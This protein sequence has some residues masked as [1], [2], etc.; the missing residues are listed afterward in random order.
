MSTA[1]VGRWKKAEECL[2]LRGRWLRLFLRT[3]AWLIAVGLM[4][5]WW[6]LCE[7]LPEIASGGDVRVGYHWDWRLH[8]QFGSGVYS[9]YVDLEL[10]PALISYRAPL[11]GQRGWIEQPLRLAMSLAWMAFPF[12]LAW[13]RLRGAAFRK[14]A[15]GW[16]LALVVLC[17]PQ[18]VVCGARGCR[19]YTTAS[20]V[21]TALLYR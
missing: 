14:A 17:F 5:F 11:R 7:T 12:A 6:V 13:W 15:W 8:K 18:A 2:P 16:G 4:V 19:T 1:A 9:G 21:A 3:A 10:G 20:T